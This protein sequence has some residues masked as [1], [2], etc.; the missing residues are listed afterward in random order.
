MSVRSCFFTTQ[1]AGHV[2]KYQEVFEK[3]RILGSFIL[4]P[5]FTFSLSGC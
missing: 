3:G 1:T 4:F 5:V 2:R